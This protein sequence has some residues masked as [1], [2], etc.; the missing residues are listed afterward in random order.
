MVELSMI[1]AAALRCGNGETE[2]LVG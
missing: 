1:Q 2:R